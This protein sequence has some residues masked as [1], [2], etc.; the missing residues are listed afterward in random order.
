MKLT[1]LKMD[2]IIFIHK[3]KSGYSHSLKC[4]YRGLKKGRIA[5]KILEVKPEWATGYYH[6]ITEITCNKN[7]CSIYKEDAQMSV[8]MNR[9]WERHH[10]LNPKTLTFE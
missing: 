3:N 6:E 2:S 9:T 7:K 8:E 5:G 4:K 1:D 10:W